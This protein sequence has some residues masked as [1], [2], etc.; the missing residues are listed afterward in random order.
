MICEIIIGSNY[1][2]I[3]PTSG[4]CFI[5]NMDTEKIEVANTL[6]TKSK[7]RYMKL[8]IFHTTIDLSEISVTAIKNALPEL[9]L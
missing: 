2:L 1:L 8:C 5:L 4:G 7:K 6:V 3:Y 9:W